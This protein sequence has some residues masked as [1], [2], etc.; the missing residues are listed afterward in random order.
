MTNRPRSNGRA[1][2]LVRLWQASGR[3]A[4]GYRADLLRHRPDGR[5]DRS[6]LRPDRHSDLSSGR[7]RTYG[8]IGGPVSLRQNCMTPCLGRF[9]QVTA[10]SRVPM[11]GSSRELPGTPFFASLPADTLSD[12]YTRPATIR[13]RS[14]QTRP[15][16]PTHPARAAGRL[17]GDA[18]RMRLLLSCNSPTALIIRRG[19]KFRAAVRKPRQARPA[20]TTSAPSQTLCPPQGRGSRSNR[21][22]P[23]PEHQVTSSVLLSSNLHRTAIEESRLGPRVRRACR[24]A[25]SVPPGEHRGG[26]E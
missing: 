14:I 9:R 20:A 25:Q 17:I 11:I 1:P 22:T 5:R 13:G 21:P 23:Q 26:K 7:R 16:A 12:F 19:R 4:A 24:A 15:Q 18:G 6:V 8:P 3:G 10:A 2:V